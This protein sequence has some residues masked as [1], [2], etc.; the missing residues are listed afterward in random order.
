MQQIN[1]SSA[2]RFGNSDNASINQSFYALQK[3]VLTSVTLRFSSVGSDPVNDVKIRCEIRRA[4]GNEN[5]LDL[6]LTPEDTSGW[7]NDENLSIGEKIFTFNNLNFDPGWYW[8]SAVTNR[9]VNLN[10][11]ALSIDKGNV[12]VGRFIKVKNG[13][14]VYD[15]NKSLYFKINTASSDSPLT[16]DTFKFDE[17]VITTLRDET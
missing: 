1:Y 4:F 14:G 13:S 5:L 17:Y 15:S 3:F 6:T 11:L 9:R 2:S 7:I 16:R 8:I 10:N 12:Y